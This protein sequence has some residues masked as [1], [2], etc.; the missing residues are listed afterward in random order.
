MEK[1][2]VQRVKRAKPQKKHPKMRKTAVVTELVESVANMRVRPK[3]KRTP[4]GA[5]SGGEIVVRRKELVA[6]VKA[7]AAAGD[8]LD[9]FSLDPT[10]LSWL[11]KL[12]KAFEK[13]QWMSVRVFWKPAVGTTVGGMV[14]LGMK[15]EHTDQKPAKREEIVALT[16][17]RTLAVWED[18]EK[19][20]LVL[21]AARLMTRKWYILGAKE[22]DKTPG[23]IQY[24]V[25]TSEVNKL[26]GEIWVEYTIRMAGTQ[27]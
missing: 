23:F 11:K 9:Q 21:P 4:R 1:I 7:P 10:S 20:P 15:W 5:T 19:Q 17:N 13:Y 25:S 22:E 18:G 8:V 26:L 14:T 27:A 6:A 24:G 16:P 3:R 2:V 12:S